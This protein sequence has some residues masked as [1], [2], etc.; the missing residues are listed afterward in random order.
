M[1]PLH[2]YP[3][4]SILYFLVI[5][6][7]RIPQF[8]SFLR[9]TSLS[10]SS[11]IARVGARAWPPSLDHDHQNI[12]VAGDGHG[13]NH[14]AHHHVKE[15]PVPDTDD[16]LSLSLSKL[17]GLGISVSLFYFDSGDV[18]PLN[19]FFS[20]SFFLLIPNK[21]IKNKKLAKRRRF[22]GSNGNG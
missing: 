12:L 20:F 21:K 9:F 19:M 3:E 14:H 1:I 15:V 8:Q 5:F 4:N 11:Y 10:N 18:V 16:Q 2:P 6:R 22:S 7:Y 17:H 13:A